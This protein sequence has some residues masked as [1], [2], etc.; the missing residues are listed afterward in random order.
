M[1]K[2]FKHPFNHSVTLM[3]PEKKLFESSR[4]KIP[5]ETIG[6]EKEVKPF[7]PEPAAL[8]LPFHPI[9]RDAVNEH[10]AS[11]LHAITPSHHTNPLVF[12]F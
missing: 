3:Q 11:S 9:P 2:K 1:M 5:L 12:C 10:L 7:D 4:R 6:T 8:S